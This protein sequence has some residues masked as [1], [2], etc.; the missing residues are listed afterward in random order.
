MKNKLQSG[1]EMDNSYDFNDKLKK[2]NKD[3]FKTM[4]KI[5]VREIN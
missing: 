5:D 3:L 1:K 2:M 4:Q